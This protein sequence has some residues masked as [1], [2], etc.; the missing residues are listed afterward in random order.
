ARGV[1][2]VDGL[3]DVEVLHQ[4][5]E[6][7]G[8]GVEVVALPGLAGAAV[9][10]AVGRD[11]AVALRGQEEHLVLGGGGAEGAAVAEH[12]RP[13]R[14]PVLV[15]ERRPVF[16]REGA[17]HVVLLAFACDLLDATTPLRW[18]A[19]QIGSGGRGWA[20]RPASSRGMAD[21]A[22]A[23]LARDDRGRGGL[24]PG[25]RQADPE[26]HARMA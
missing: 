20:V 21:G 8:V 4:R 1:A 25:T 2:D 26:T 14:A 15:V 3:P 7:V 17:R 18:A 23:D 11:A 9:P 24:D 10:A 5:R 19:R 6:V 16:G 12:Q 13:A 22:S